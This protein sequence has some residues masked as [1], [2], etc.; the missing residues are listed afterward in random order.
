MLFRARTSTGTGTDMICKVAVS[1]GEV[2]N[3]G[4]DSSALDKAIAL[5]NNNT[6]DLAGI[7]LPT[8]HE[9]LNFL[10]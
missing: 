7:V 4:N 1:S 6:V 5:L 8:V 2:S 10:K 9:I 3:I